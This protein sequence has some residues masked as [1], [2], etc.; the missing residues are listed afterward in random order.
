MLLRL[1]GS[2]MVAA[3]WLQG[4]SGPAR[5]YYRISAAGRQTLHQATSDWHAFSGGVGSL[6]KEVVS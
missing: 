3:D 4:A 6:L 2:G 5:K 1:E